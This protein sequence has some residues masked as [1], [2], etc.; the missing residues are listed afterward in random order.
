MVAA[1]RDSRMFNGIVAEN[2]GIDLPRAGIAE[3]WNEQQLAPLATSTDVN[4]QPYLPPT[5]P[6]SGS[7]SCVRRNPERM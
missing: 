1:A 2:P 3:A 7:G 6:P 5:V 4:G